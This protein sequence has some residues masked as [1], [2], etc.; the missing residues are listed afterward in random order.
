M[1][2]PRRPS[3]ASRENT[4]E[5]MARVETRSDPI[6]FKFHQIHEVGEVIKSSTVVRSMAHTDVLVAPLQPNN[7]T[8]F[9]HSID[10]GESHY[11]YENLQSN[12]RSR[13]Q[14]GRA[15]HCDARRGCA[16]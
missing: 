3:A 5:K 9:Y 4:L 13:S 1:L 12:T 8:N 15:R 2:K 10:I 7:V 16:T 14:A 11:N 6:F